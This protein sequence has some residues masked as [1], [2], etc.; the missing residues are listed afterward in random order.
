MR[1]SG[2][3]FATSALLTFAV[4]LGI[5]IWTAPKPALIAVCLVGLALAVFDFHRTAIRRRPAGR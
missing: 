3:I 2:V 1:A 5:L 4:F